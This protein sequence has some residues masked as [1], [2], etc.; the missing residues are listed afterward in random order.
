MEAEKVEEK[1]PTEV[2]QK[3]EVDESSSDEEEER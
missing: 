2:E 1:K 3:P